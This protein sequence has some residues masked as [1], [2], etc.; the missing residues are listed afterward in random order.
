MNILPGTITPVIDLMIYFTLLRM[1]LTLNFIKYANKI[2]QALGVWKL[3]YLI[4]PKYAK[5]MDGRHRKRE[6][7]ISYN[8]KYSPKKYLTPV[9]YMLSSWW[10]KFLVG[11][12]QYVI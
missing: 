9:H 1:V 11:L 3:K 2:M 12:G 8:L 6:G 5:P 10:E 4:P 7:Y